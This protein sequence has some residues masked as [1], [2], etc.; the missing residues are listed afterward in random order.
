MDATAKPNRAPL[1]L[2]Q[3][4]YVVAIAD[5][6]SFGAAASH[7]HV[8]Q[9]G[10]STQVRE[11]ERSLGGTD[12]VI[13]FDC[14]LRRLDAESRQVRH[15]VDEIYRRIA[16]VMPEKLREKLR[17]QASPPRLLLTVRGKG[18]RWG[19]SPES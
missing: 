2:R 1:T 16:D 10:L 8:S 15:S 6:K 11:V 3:L 4:E 18:Y 14:I 5:E 13:G 12:I 7:C 19:A 17:D 9:P